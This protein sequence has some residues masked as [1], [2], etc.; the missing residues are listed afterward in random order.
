MT[1]PG[2]REIVWENPAALRYD[3]ERDVRYMVRT[4]SSIPGKEWRILDRF[5]SLQ[6]AEDFAVAYSVGHP[7]VP[8]RIE[9]FIP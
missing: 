6:E 3:E 4:P 8:V 5:R 7:E 2:V 9:R 1:N